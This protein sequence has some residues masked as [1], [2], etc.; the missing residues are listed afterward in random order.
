M[1]KFNRDFGHILG[2]HIRPG[3]QG[4]APLDIAAPRRSSTPSHMRGPA[5][6][7]QTR[8]PAHPPIT[9]PSAVKLQA[10]MHLIASVLASDDNESLGAELLR[11]LEHRTGLVVRTPQQE[12]SLRNLVDLA[13]IK[14][15]RGLAEEVS[16]ED[17]DMWHN[18]KFVELR[19]ESRTPLRR[20]EICEFLARGYENCAEGECRAVQIRDSNKQG[21]QAGH[22][23][24][25][26]WAG[27]GPHPAIEH[28]LD[29]MD[30][31]SVRTTFEGEDAIV[32]FLGDRRSRNYPRTRPHPR[33]PTPAPIHTPITTMRWQGVTT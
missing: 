25:F 26:T 4:V 13:D 32:G 33:G 30:I 17:A 29:V 9:E 11:E 23:V 14:A 3:Q 8:G 27:D 19:E 16:L 6:R 28:M 2:F 31:E 12:A 21:M 24:V 20:D 10:A 18:S 5:V 22:A 15:D 7:G 1:T